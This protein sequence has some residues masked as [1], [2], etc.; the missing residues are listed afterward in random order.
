MELASHSAETEIEADH[1]WFKGRRRLFGRILQRLGIP[2]DARILDAG[3]SSG[4]NLRLLRD[5]GY[6]NFTGLEISAHAIALCK[7]KGLGPIEPGD[8]CAMPFP[9]ASFD[10]VLATDIIE[11]VD[12]DD[13][14]LKEML[15][16]LKPG[17]HCL[18][19]VPAFQSLWGHEDVKLHHKRRYRMPALLERVRAAGLAPVESYYFNYLLFLPI[20]CVRRLARARP[21]SQRNETE[22]APFLNTVLSAIFALDTRTA[23]LLKPGF[24][25]S[26]LVLAR[27]ETGA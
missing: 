9:D 8:I 24:G 23:P 10:F 26:A 15:R 21:P 4:S 7:A 6:S 27:R 25:V 3:S 18:V 5:E 11:H 22:F 19:T 20:W 13:L 2:K 17:G 1:W 16:V 12:R 14:A